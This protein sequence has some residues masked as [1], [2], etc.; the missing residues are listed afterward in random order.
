VS[1][2]IF[3][4]SHERAGAA[5]VTDRNSWHLG[6]LFMA[7]WNASILVGGI[8]ED[9]LVACLLTQRWHRYIAIGALGG[10]PGSWRAHTHLLRVIRWENNSGLEIM[11]E[12]KRVMPLHAV[13]AYWISRCTAT[14]ILRFGAGWGGGGG[15]WA[16]SR[17]GCFLPLEKTTDSH[18]IRGQ[19]RTTADMGPSESR[20]RLAI[21][22]SSKAGE[23]DE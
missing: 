15:E 14:V 6:H 11:K 21:L 1:D 5:Q 3:Q 23:V 7:A 13:K 20:Y 19:V 10:G 16:F 12:V 22:V 4:V 9:L 18:W 17:P 8:G 2:Y